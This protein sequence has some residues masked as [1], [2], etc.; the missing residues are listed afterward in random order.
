MTPTQTGLPNNIG[1]LLIE[2]SNGL[3]F[4]F[5]QTLR[6]LKYKNKHGAFLR[7]YRKTRKGGVKTNKNFVTVCD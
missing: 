7:T 4:R 5:F 1:T 2:I 3:G 6:P